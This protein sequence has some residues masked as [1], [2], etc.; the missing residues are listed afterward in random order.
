MLRWMVYVA[1]I[2]VLLALITS[3]TEKEFKTYVYNRV[4][5]AHCKPLIQ[6]TSYKLAYFRLFSLDYVKECKKARSAGHLPDTV[7]KQAYLGLFG[8]FWEL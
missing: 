6:Y 2:V 8:T 3:P 7:K 1:L 5:T 4:D